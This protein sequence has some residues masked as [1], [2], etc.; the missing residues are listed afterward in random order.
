[1]A[2]VSVEP[3]PKREDE[4]LPSHSSRDL[5][6]AMEYIERNYLQLDGTHHLY[7]SFAPRI[8]F[9]RRFCSS[10]A[11]VRSSEQPSGAVGVHFY[12]LYVSKQ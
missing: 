12:A 8:D 2:V 5:N 11:A 10:R 7:E 6:S 3:T 4:P 1:M 9:V